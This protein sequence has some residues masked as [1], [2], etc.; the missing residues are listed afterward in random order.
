MKEIYLGKGCKL[1]ACF[2]SDLIQGMKE[3]REKTKKKGL[4]VHGYRGY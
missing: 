1:F 4:D 2:D 3:S